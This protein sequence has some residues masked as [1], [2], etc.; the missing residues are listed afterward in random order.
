MARLH[1]QAAE[2]AAAVAQSTASPRPVEA[3]AGAMARPTAP[4]CQW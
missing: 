1:V 3:P 4:P 2:G